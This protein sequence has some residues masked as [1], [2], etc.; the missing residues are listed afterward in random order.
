MRRK[1]VRIREV[2][3][4]MGLRGRSSIYERIYDKTIPPQIKLGGIVG[5][6]EHEIEALLSAHAAGKSR[7]EI[8]DL[9]QRLTEARKVG[10]VN[11]QFL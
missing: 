7:D 4:A 9:V 10:A 3:D 2:L 6:F 8:R 1:I 11:V 5:W